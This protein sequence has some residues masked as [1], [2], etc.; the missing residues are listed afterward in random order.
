MSAAAQPKRLN[1]RLKKFDM[2]KIKHDKVV[3]LIGKRETGKSF[4]VKDLLWH[5]QSLPCGTVISGT[6][7]ANQFYSKVVPPMFIHEAYSPLI[8][9]NVLKRQKLIAKKIANDLST[10]GTTA[11]DPRNFLILDDCLYDTRWI[12]DDNIRYLFMNGRHVHTMFIITM[13]YAIGIPPNLRTNIDYVFILRENYISNRRKLY[14]QYAGMFPDFDSFCQVMN[15]CTE[16]FE[17]LVIDNNAKSNKLEDQVFWYKAAPHGD[18]KLCAPEYWIQSAN[19][20]R[21]EEEE[22]DFNPGSQ[23]GSRRKYQLNVQRH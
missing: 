7:G 14:E 20:H 19:Y 10:R 17:C 16:N 13:Q 4:L 5:H 1:L 21:D 3:V 12:R 23:P 11:V 22:E 18:F 9:A 8:I 15:M 2:T 6:E